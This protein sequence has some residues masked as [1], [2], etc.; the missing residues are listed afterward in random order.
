MVILL[1]QTKPN[2]SAL[3][4]PLQMAAHMLDWGDSLNPHCRGGK[5]L[6]M[7]VM[8]VGCLVLG[9]NPNIIL[10][11]L[12]KTYVAGVFCFCPNQNNG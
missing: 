10:F 1:N 6:T 11:L 9:D 5:Q 3:G 4:Q 2:V 8:F 12:Y 7:V